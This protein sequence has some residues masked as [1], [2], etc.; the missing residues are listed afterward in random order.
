MLCESNDHQVPEEIGGNIEGVTAFDAE[1]NL[2]LLKIAETGVPLSLK[3]SDNVQI[4]EKVY[5]LGYQHDLRY[6]GDSGQAPEQ[7]QRRHM[8]ANKNPI[9]FWERWGAYPKQ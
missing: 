6:K 1:N 2:V 4:G 5:T 9:F 7:I 8:D 3:N